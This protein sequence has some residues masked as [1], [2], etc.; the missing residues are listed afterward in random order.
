MPGRVN[1]RSTI[2]LLEVQHNRALFHLQPHTG[3][4]HQL[5]IH[6]SGLGCGI[7]HDRYYPQL[8]PERADNFQTP[9]QLLAKSIKFRD[10]LS[11]IGREFSSER[12]LMW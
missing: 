8:Q 11:G 10:P 6:L 1:A 7:E 9:L 5:R 2:S 3:K 4:T 12:E